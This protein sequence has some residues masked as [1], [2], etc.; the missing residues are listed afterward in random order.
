LIETQ[1]PK[2]NNCKF[3]SSQFSVKTKSVKKSWYKKQQIFEEA[4]WQLCK[5]GPR[6]RFCWISPPKLFSCRILPPQFEGSQQPRSAGPE[7][8]FA[9]DSSR[10]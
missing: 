7:F 10:E 4:I 8:S 1:K 5:C 6:L 2:K 9:R 3:L